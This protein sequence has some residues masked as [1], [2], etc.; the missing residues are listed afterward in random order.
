MRRSDNKKRIAIGIIAVF[1]AAIMIL[2]MIAPFLQGLT[3]PKPDP[4]KLQGKKTESILS[5]EMTYDIL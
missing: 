4:L 3:N 1:L 2:G 5:L